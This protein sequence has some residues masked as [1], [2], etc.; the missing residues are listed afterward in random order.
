MIMVKETMCIASWPPNIRPIILINYRTPNGRWLPRTSPVW[1][2]EE[3]WWCRFNEYVDN[4]KSNP[5]CSFFGQINTWING[6]AW[7]KGQRNVENCHISFL[8]S[9][10]RL[11][12]L[13]SWS[14]IRKH[15]KTRGL[16]FPKRQPQAR[17][18]IF[19]LVNIY[20]PA[21]RKLKPRK[22]KDKRKNTKACFIGFGPSS[23]LC[24]PISASVAGFAA[25]WTPPPP[26]STV[27]VYRGPILHY[28]SEAIDAI[29]IKSSSQLKN[30]SEVPPAQAAHYF[31][32]LPSYLWG[33][34]EFTLHA[35]QDRW[36]W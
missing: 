6:E 22:Y 2:H 26:Y 1:R 36:G 20:F 7:L 31:I 17:C 32:R 4:L 11:I 33:W 14:I 5:N 16:L 21:H 8:C 35:A 30:T 19:C 13:E 9:I 3:L 29:R 23:V 25:P 18:K 28:S 12:G 24:F 10:R 34:L 27:S 15:R